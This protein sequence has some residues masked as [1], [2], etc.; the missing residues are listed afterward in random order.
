M[1]LWTWLE[2]QAPVPFVWAAGCGVSGWTKPLLSIKLQRERKWMID[3]DRESGNVGEG[4]G[5]ACVCAHGVLLQLNMPT[6]RA[7]GSQWCCDPLLL[8]VPGS[9]RK[10]LMA[11][12]T[13]V[14]VCE[15]VL[16]S[17]CL[18]THHLKRF[19]NVPR[20]SKIFALP[21]VRM[22]IGF[23][24]LYLNEWVRNLLRSPIFLQDQQWIS[25]LITC[26]DNDFLRKLIN[27][28]FKM[29]FFCGLQLNSLNQRYEWCK[30]QS[31]VGQTEGIFF[32]FLL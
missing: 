15:Q 29:D 25:W 2:G 23:C 21:G 26:L 22:R 10:S 14:W 30:G 1:W 20:L 18:L 16:T 31:F 7:D 3:S 24:L 5:E 8:C 27:I 32:L 28:L 11:C 17:A 19:R 13:L 12:G 9:M 6:H 4:G